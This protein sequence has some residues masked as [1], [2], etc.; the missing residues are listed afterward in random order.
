MATN[1]LCFLNCLYIDKDYFTKFAEFSITNELS[2][3][4]LYVFA[5]EGK[6]KELINLKNQGRIKADFNIDNNFMKVLSVEQLMLTEKNIERLN[7]YAKSKPSKVIRPLNNSIYTLLIK[8]IDNDCAFVDLDIR[9]KIGVAWHKPSPLGLIN[10]NELKFS[11][12]TM[13]F[14]ASMLNHEKKWTSRKII[15]LDDEE[16]LSVRD[17]N[18]ITVQRNKK[19]FMDID[20]LEFIEETRELCLFKCVADKWL[21]NAYDVV[22]KCAFPILNNYAY[23]SKIYKAVYSL[24]NIYSTEY[25]NVVTL[26]SIAESSDNYS[27]RPSSKN[28][29]FVKTSY[30]KPKRDTMRSI[31]KLIHDKTVNGI[32][33]VQYKDLLK[34]MNSSSSNIALKLGAKILIDVI[35]ESQGNKCTILV[36]LAKNMDII[37]NKVFKYDN[38]IYAHRATE[39]INLHRETDIEGRNI[40]DIKTLNESGT[41]YKSDY[42]IR[43]GF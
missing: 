37:L 17:F 15:G 38:F 6:I 21:P 34:L 10:F 40:Y 35:Y 43:I 23:K 2:L 13:S 3:D 30:T 18:F 26:N 25:C 39:Y 24:L 12:S 5:N 32:N 33:E 7:L 9:N 27:R 36:N 14:Y 16:I 1:K 28:G 11:E 20:G 29:I 4:Y 41:D 8:L 19:N 22:E 31:C 42:E